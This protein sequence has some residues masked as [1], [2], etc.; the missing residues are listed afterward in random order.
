M[1]R[2][3]RT[4]GSALLLVCLSSVVLHAGPQ[5]T[6]CVLRFR[7]VDIP[8]V[9]ATDMQ[10]IGLSVADLVA[11]HLSTKCQV[12]ERERINLMLKE[13]ALG[14][15]GLT[16]GAG[17]DAAKFLRADYAVGGSYRVV[18]AGSINLWF[19][20]IRAD[21]GAVKG[22]HETGGRLGDL[23][24]IVR[25]SCIE[26]LAKLDLPVSKQEME[27]LR[28]MPRISLDA[29]KSL[30]LGLQW[31]DSGNRH[32]ALALF[33]SAAR[34]ENPHTE[35]GFWLGRLYQEL[36]ELE[37]A[38]VEWDAAC[39]RLPSAPSTAETRW[40]LAETLRR[41][42]ARERPAAEAYAALCRQFPSSPRVF[43]AYMH[44]GEYYRAV[45]DYKSAWKAFENACGR[46]SWRDTGDCWGEMLRCL[47][48]ALNEG[49]TNRVNEAT[50]SGGYW[51]KAF[52]V[53]T[54]SPVVKTPPLERMFFIAPPGMVFESVKYEVDVRFKVENHPQYCAMIKFARQNIRRISGSLAGEEAFAAPRNIVHGIFYGFE[55]EAGQATFSFVLKKGP[56]S[57]FPGHP[58]YVAPSTGVVTSGTKEVLP[59]EDVAVVRDGSGRFH[60]V[61]NEGALYVMIPIG[62]EQADL[63]VAS[64]LPE[65]DWSPPR[66]L[67]V[68]AT[69]L[70]WQP[71][72]LRSSQGTDIL[73]W[74]SRRSKSGED[75]IWLAD[76]DV[77]GTLSDPR[78]LSSCS[79]GSGPKSGS[80]PH[81]ME[82]PDGGLM[83]LFMTGDGTWWGARS[84]DG[85]TWQEAHRVGPVGLS[86]FMSSHTDRGSGLSVGLWTRWTASPYW[87][88]TK[89]G[90]DWTFT[91]TCL[92]TAWRVSLTRDWDRVYW[93][94]LTISGLVDRKVV[95]SCSY[96]GVDWVD[97]LPMRVV[98]GPEHRVHNALVCDGANRLLAVWSRPAGKGSNDTVSAACNVVGLAPVTDELRQQLVARLNNTEFRTL[99]Q[100]R[101]QFAVLATQTRT[102]L[103]AKQPDVDGI[104][105]SL[106]QTAS[107]L[108]TTAPGLL[109]DPRNIGRGVG[110]PRAT[111]YELL[112]RAT[113]VVSGNAA[114]VSQTDRL[115]SSVAGGGDEGLRSMAWSL[116]GGASRK[117]GDREAAIRYYG[118]AKAWPELVDLA[119]E[120]GD[121]DA[122]VRY[123]DASGNRD[124]MLS[125]AVRLMDAGDSARALRVLE[126][127]NAGVVRG[128]SI[129]LQYAQMLVELYLLDN[130][131]ED[132]V[133]VLD[134]FSTRN[135]FHGNIERLAELRQRLEQAKTGGAGN[136]SS[137][138]AQA[139][140]DSLL[141]PFRLP[142]STPRPTAANR[143]LYVAC[144]GRHVTPFDSA[145]K[146]ATNLA[147]VL[148]VA[149][150]GDIIEVARG[151]YGVE[152]EIVVNKG[153]LIRG[154]GDPRATTLD[155]RGDVRVLALNHPAAVVERFTITGGTG[156]GQGHAY[157]GGV[158]LND[159]TLR[160]CLVTGNSGGAG[161]GVGV[162]G[163]GAI[164]SCAMTRNRTSSRGGGLWIH[165]V[166]RVVVRDCAIVGNQTASRG[167]GVSAESG[168]GE[169]ILMERCLIYHNRRTGG[170]GA[171][172]MELHPACV[173]R[174][175]I[176][177]ENH[178]GGPAGDGVIA[179]NG[180]TLQNC[181]IARNSCY[182]GPL[183]T[184]DGK[185]IN[186][187]IFGNTVFT[188]IGNASFSHCCTERKVQGEGNIVADPLFMDPSH[189][190]FRLRPGSPCPGAGVVGEPY[191]A[192][193]DRRP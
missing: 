56:S 39:R 84:Q 165:G 93:A 36:G 89:D 179:L 135:P 187:I 112:T 125:V 23:S 81:L 33:R 67:A 14:T 28:S 142:A 79:T 106:E 15:T 51:G 121:P 92:P 190:D 55:C 101:R 193:S 152:Q 164:E 11:T 16:E 127:D 35:A 186:S 191:G 59:V 19:W 2:L 40:L 153:V 122:A 133:G 131:L 87:A 171:G 159:G 50:L 173:L 120:A 124:L 1:T 17:K 63:F 107:F 162:L 26:L 34:G 128:G 85:R 140:M 104:L 110:V 116:L 96:D 74:L 53:E 145:E 7:N 6:V 184:R 108:M 102:L 180:G 71:S 141:N 178:E 5:P 58:G 126:T 169:T 72:V 73:A 105:S 95:L 61:F 177:A 38:V 10:W 76:G 175:C 111:F 52:Y 150:D 176:I 86:V 90:D 43:A 37:H 46:R 174:D 9:A 44:Q 130:R 75:R 57:I 91:E 146:A 100:S 189:L 68:S 123:C 99:S 185:V 143:V 134:G 60:V 154:T 69:G 47:S 136:A 147:S 4:V 62:R 30:G 129:G 188:A 25:E 156:R 160:Q 137:S 115:L 161:G 192:G 119:M 172:A 114:F 49:D 88:T 21:T 66:R 167:G 163:S 144:D 109:G 158:L 82:L 24:G 148:A 54:E 18:D 31:Y 22:V 27:T 94:A 64:S 41:D 48:L 181:T 183:I 20:I 3:G 98:A 70:D 155:G 13:L 170:G 118:L 78:S 132:A 138:E 83:L 117:R 103:Q 8:S 157:G 32:R 45:K 182:H 149:K 80:Y 65:G 29:L 12:V 42:L 151:T 97:P 139:R 77:G 113:S 168:T 166:G